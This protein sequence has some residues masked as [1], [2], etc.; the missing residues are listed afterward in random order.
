M[1]MTLISTDLAVTPIIWAPSDGN[2]VRMLLG[3]DAVKLELERYIK[4]LYSAL[5][6]Q[7]STLPVAA[8]ATILRDRLLVTVTIDTEAR[9]MR[10]GRTGY[11]L[12]LGLWVD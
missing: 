7:K 5:A 11:R 1:A 6:E 4:G 12:A 9:D 8:H 10:D 3:P 2:E